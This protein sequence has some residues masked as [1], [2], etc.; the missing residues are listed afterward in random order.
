MTGRKPDEQTVPLQ[1]LFDELKQHLK[2]TTVES[3][4]ANKTPQQVRAVADT[5]TEA[6]GSAIEG[7][8]GP[9]PPERA[10][11]CKKGCAHCCHLA[12][13]TDGATTLRIATYVREKF[14]NAERMLLDMRLIAYEDK[15]EKMTQSQRSMAYL[16]CPLL[17][18]GAC[19]VH[20]VR[21]L[22]CRAFNSY[23]VEECKR[24]LRPGG[25]AAEI[26][27]WGVPWLVGLALDAGLKDALLESGYAEGDLELGLSLKAA[28][29]HP[30]ADERWLA[31]DK[32][33]A[34]AAWKARRP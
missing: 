5:T 4:R 28:L 17:V 12:V 27:G 1:P 23:D 13:L 16:P 2:K 34:R 15:V 32:L 10:L 33:F 18:D 3:L 29:D 6:F 31:G 22:I 24:Q 19:T 14:S 7:L 20:P 11:D 8:L 30:Q 21:P 26:P 25:S 9:V